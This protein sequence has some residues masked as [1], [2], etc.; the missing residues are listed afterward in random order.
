MTSPAELPRAGYDLAS[1]QRDPLV[2]EQRDDLPELV[3]TLPPT[4]FVQIARGLRD[5]DRLDLVL[6]HAS[7]EQLTALLDLDGWSRDRLA[8]EKA[9]GWLVAIVD[10]YA[11]TGKRRGHLRNVIE[12]MDPEMW[13]MALLP[14]TA[15]YEL[16]PDDVELREQALAAV[17]ALFPY[18]TPDGGF[19]VAVPDNELGHMAIHV[20]ERVYADDLQLGRDMTLSLR[21]ALPAQLEEDLL[22]W[23]SGRL[24]DLGFVDWEEAMKLFRPLDAKSAREASAEPTTP[25]PARE[26]EA[27]SVA[28]PS[29]SAGLLRRVLGGLPAGEQGVRAREFTLLVNELMSAQRSEP[30]DPKAQER[31]FHQAE[32]TVSLGLEVLMVGLGLPPAEVDAFLAGRIAALGLRGVFRVGYGPLATLRKTALALHREGRV[33]LAKIGSL[34]DRP[35]GPA[36]EGLSRWLP[37]LPIESAGSGWRPIAGLRDVARATEL[38]AQ[39]GAL[40]ALTFDPRGYAIDPQWVSRVDEPDR[41]TLGDLVRTSAL[42]RQLPGMSEET[43]AAFA[44][45]DADDLAWAADHLLVNGRL[46]PGLAADLRK[47]CLAIGAPQHAE[48]FV[49]AVLLRLEVEL[50]ALER[51]EEGTVDLRRAGGVITPQRIGV[52]LK[53][54]LSAS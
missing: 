49:S 45:V 8:V 51:D 22:R 23:R 15:V 28:F 16:D 1:V 33:S 3:P 17:D 32:A 34:L 29:P 5:E 27:L 47:R 50:G 42:R 46:A 35:W 2:L 13:T 12:D 24:A 37:E 20:L 43:A 38:L 10:A 53:T 40:A 4:A 41:L 9:R 54:G 18:E 7:P 21:G 11:M 26:G 52:W 6:P 44:P 31:A 14:G 48:A 25:A 39:A 30:G 19:I 36:L